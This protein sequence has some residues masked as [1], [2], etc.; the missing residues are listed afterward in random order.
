L[1]PLPLPPLP[2][3][4]PAPAPPLPDEPP[5]PPVVPLAPP[6]PDEPPLA[7]LPAPLAP[8]LPPSPES[9]SP[10]SSPLHDAI[11]A[12][13]ETTHI[14]WARRVFEEWTGSM[15]SKLPENG[16]TLDP[17]R[18]T[19]MT[20]DFGVHHSARA[21]GTVGYSRWRTKAF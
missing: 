5:S 10:L 11:S 13:A 21:P 15:A 7:P 17:S 20:A 9:L 18:A 4:A 2:P 6:L 1:P 3:L 19:A 12:R 8:L 14:S 16:S